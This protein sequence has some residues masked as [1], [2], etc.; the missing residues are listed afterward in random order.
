MDQRGHGAS[1]CL[2]GGS[3]RRI[4]LDGTLGSFVRFHVV[5]ANGDFTRAELASE[6]FLARDQ[7]SFAYAPGGAGRRS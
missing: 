6:H 3:R 4:D 5:V 2:H 1:L 7:A